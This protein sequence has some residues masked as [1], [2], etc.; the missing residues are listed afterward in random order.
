MHA[1]YRWVDR[2]ETFRSEEKIMAIMIC[3]KHACSVAGL[4][5]CGL[6]FPTSITE[7]EWPSERLEVGFIGLHY[8]ICLNSLYNKYIQIKNLI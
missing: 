3:F 8:F 7:D 6:S 4:L 2:R 1:R 5:L